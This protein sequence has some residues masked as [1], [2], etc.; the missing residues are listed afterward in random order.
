MVKAFKTSSTHWVALPCALGQNPAPGNGEPDDLILANWVGGGGGGGRGG[1]K[2]DDGVHLYE[3]SPIPFIR[4][5]S[6]AY[7]W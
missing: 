2:N 7:L 5:T 6:S 1:G 4:A 3:L